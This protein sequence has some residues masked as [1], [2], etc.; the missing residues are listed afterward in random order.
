[1]KLSVLTVCVADK[2]LEEALS[3]LSGLGVQQVELG[4]GGFPGKAHIDPDVLL[5]DD[6]ALENVK[7]LLEKYNMRIS[8]LA[9]H[10]IPVHPQQEISEKADY[11]RK[12]AEQLEDEMNIFKL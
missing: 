7:N 4:A 6:A 2:T 9:L 3:Y 1:M 10:V 8:A 12:I 11:L 5:K